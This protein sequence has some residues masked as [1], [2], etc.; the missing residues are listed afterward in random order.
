MNTQQF[1][2]YKELNI[3][4]KC[5]P[6][7]IRKAY[8]KLALKF[9]PD[10]GGDVEKFKRITLAHST[11]SDP[12][13]RQQYDFSLNA[14]VFDNNMMNDPLSFLFKNGMN[15]FFS[16]TTQK[17]DPYNP[18]HKADDVIL[19]YNI[20]IEEMFNGCEKV[21][22]FKRNVFCVGCSGRGFK[23]RDDFKSCVG[24]NGTGCGRKVF[25]TNG[26]MT[27]RTG[28]CKDCDGK[29]YSIKNK[30]SDCDGTKIKSTND[31]ETLTLP[32]GIDKRQH[33]VNNKGNQKSKNTFTNLIILLDVQDS[34][35]EFKRDAYDI[36]TTIKIPFKSTILGVNMH[37]K[38]LNNKIIEID[39]PGPVSP[40]K[41]YRIDGHGI[42][43]NGDL[44][45]RFK[46]T[47]PKEFSQEF[48]DIAE[49]LL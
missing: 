31:S 16:M 26:V 49:K 20:S 12:Q 46:V 1:N 11:L 34:N 13:K 36:I 38:H 9:H 48:K 2:L 7:E 45:V 19:Q 4:E 18:I 28:P 6:D 39:L 42:D 47:W 43:G 14:P 10:K 27:V 37:L 30:C 24:C 44:I 17:T 40:D 21:F 23:N 33:I 15:S 29:G 41:K 35:D 32:P 3:D 25:N 8:R 22:K 5:S